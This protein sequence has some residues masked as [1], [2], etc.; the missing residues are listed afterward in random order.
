[1]AETMSNYWVNFA[2]TGSPN[3]NNQPV[4]DKYSSA[5]PNYVE[6]DG[7]ARPASNLLPAN[8]D[9]FDKVMAAR[10]Q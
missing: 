5:E 6:L 10:R 2:R 9:L 4:W 7:S 3:G 8:W 1:M